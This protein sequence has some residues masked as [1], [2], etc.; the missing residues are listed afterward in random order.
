M[1]DERLT[2]GPGDH[3]KAVGPPAFWDVN[4]GLQFSLLFAL[5][6]REHHTLLDIGCGSLRGGRLF[7]PYLA[8]GNYYGIEPDRSLVEAGLRD[9]LGEC[10]ADLKQPHFEYR[11]DFAFFVWERRFDFMVAQSIL[12]HT[13]HDQARRLLTN[14]HESL[15]DD[16]VL[17]AT[18]FWR[19]P[20]AGLHVQRPR[21]TEGTGWTGEFGVAYEWSEMEHMARDAGLALRRLHFPHPRQTW[22]IAVR[23]THASRLRRLAQRADHWPATA[24]DLHRA[25]GIRNRYPRLGRAS[26]LAARARRRRPRS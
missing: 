10:V 4:A 3:R 17:A 9:E 24:R 7:I 15:A 25:D 12:S 13:H 18:F 5:G 20:V 19:R 11:D 2:H 16:G 21:G 8:T 26:A 22:F 6:L 14:A 23:Q 1:G